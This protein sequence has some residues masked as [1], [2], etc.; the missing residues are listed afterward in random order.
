[1]TVRESFLQILRK[2]SQR[3]M[4]NIMQHCFINCETIYA[5][6]EEEANLGRPRLLHDTQDAI[7]DYGFHQIDY[8]LIAQ[9][10]F[11]AIILYLDI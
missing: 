6:R 7:L 8:L 11:P 9:T 3:S 10:W 2:L 4:A 1:V 5:K